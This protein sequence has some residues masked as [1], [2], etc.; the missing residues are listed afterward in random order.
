M[1]AKNWLSLAWSILLA[2][3]ARLG[4]P[5]QIAWCAGPTN[6]NG[7]SFKYEEPK[8]LTGTIYAKQATREQALFKFKRVATRSGSNLEVVREYNHPTGESAAKE[9]IIYEK[10]DLVSYELEETQAAAR[11]SAKIR[12]DPSNPAK[13]LVVFHY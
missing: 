3:S 1:M 11:G 9:R 6:P 7:V 13:R 10:D 4:G 2:A 5:G 8:I 12:Q